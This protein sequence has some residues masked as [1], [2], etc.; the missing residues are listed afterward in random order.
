MEDRS[1][2]RPYSQKL[3]EVRRLP[4]EGEQDRKLKKEAARDLRIE[5]YLSWAQVAD[6]TI[7]TLLDKPLISDDELQAVVDRQKPIIPKPEIADAFLNS[8]VLARN[9][10]LVAV[11]VFRARAEL[12]ETDKDVLDWPKREKEAVGQLLFKELTGLGPRDKVRLI[13]TTIAVGVELGEEDFEALDPRINVSGFYMETQSVK[14]GRFQKDKLNFPFIG[15]RRDERQG[16]VSRHEIAH[17]INASITQALI[18]SD[19][20]LRGWVWGGEAESPQP[21]ITTIDEFNRYLRQRALPNALARA[22]DEI[23]ADYA[24]SRNFEHLHALAERHGLYDFFDER[25]MMLWKRGLSDVGQKGENS[26]VDSL[27]PEYI[28]LITNAAKVAQEVDKIYNEMWLE[29]RRGLFKYVLAQIPLSDWATVIE[30]DF[31]DEARAFHRSQ[32]EGI[33]LGAKITTT[34]V[35]FDAGAKFGNTPEEQ[36]TKRATLVAISERIYE[37]LGEG[38]ERAINQPLQSLYPLASEIGG[39]IEHLKSQYE[40]VK[41]A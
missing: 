20:R 12:P 33:S 35:G 30:R 17:A 7:E 26:A 38:L 25:I 24:A 14:I 39:K 16:R 21:K 22:K 5:S 10:S 37:I 3:E 13:D 19:G 2:D 11:R 4:T 9:R 28:E 6:S 40:T 32:W 31:L 8:L 15:I 18:A 1:E 29:R 27:W 36:Q 34:I 23:I 41:R